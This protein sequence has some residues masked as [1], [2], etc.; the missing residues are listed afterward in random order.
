MSELAPL[1]TFELRISNGVCTLRFIF[2]SY[3]TRVWIDVGAHHCEMSA[4][5][6]LADPTLGVIAIEPNPGAWRVWPLE[7]QPRLI[8][9]PFGV[10]EQE[11]A[12]V[13]VALWRSMPQP[14]LPR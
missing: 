11:R 14:S 7:R 2:P 1:G 6:L 4:D 3:V 12:Q 9:L 13:F 8:G 5:K 10:D